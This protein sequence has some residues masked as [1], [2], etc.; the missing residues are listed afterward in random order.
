MID[1]PDQSFLLRHVERRLA[2]SGMDLAGFL[3]GEP[4]RERERLTATVV[5][6]GLE[7][8]R[9]AAAARAFVDRLDG[10]AREAW[11]REFTRAIFLVG[12][13]RRLA[14]RFRFDHVSA[15]GAC[16]WMAPAPA[17]RHESLRRLLRPLRTERRFAPPARV[18]V[19]G[20]RGRAV[21]LWIAMRGLRPEDYLVHL[22]H[23]LCEAAIEGA[24]Q[25]DE[26]LELAHVEALDDLPDAT[27]YLRVHRDRERADQL[28][29]YAALEVTGE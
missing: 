11:H 5:L 2:A 28:R 29:L 6:R 24:L 26:R 13:P 15:D 21:R 8:G 10:A 23:A 19:G 16:A 27:V 3:A 18:T 1:V 25:P 12:D 9:F 20:G 17:S 7:P 22:H 4:A 14:A